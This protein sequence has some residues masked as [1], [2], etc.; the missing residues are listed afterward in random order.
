MLIKLPADGCFYSNRRGSETL[1]VL[2]H[3]NEDEN[4]KIKKTPN[5]QCHHWHPAHCGVTFASLLKHK[6]L[7][8]VR[9]S[10]WLFIYLGFGERVTDGTVLLLSFSSSS[11]LVLLANQSGDLQPIT[12]HLGVYKGRVSVYRELFCQD[13]VHSCFSCRRPVT[14]FL[15]CSVFLLRLVGLDWLL[16][17]FAQF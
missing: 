9:L 4:L 13:L 3:L 8:I 2:P 6:S 14:V 16:T 11:S 10:H 1:F 15:F 5:S 7:I 17:F 12:V